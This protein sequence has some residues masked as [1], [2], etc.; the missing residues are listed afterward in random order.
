MPEVIEKSQSK[1]APMK[2]ASIGIVVVAAGRGSRAQTEL[3]KQ[4][5]TLAGKTV[6][7]RTLEA[8]QK[9]IPDARIVCVIHPDDSTLYSKA[10]EGLAGLHHVLGGK[11]RQESVLNGLN[12]LKAESP[13]YAFVHDAARPFVSEVLIKN[14]L[15]TLNEGS[16][17]V[18]PALAV[19]DTLKRVDQNTIAD[20]VDRSNLYSVQTPQ[21]FDFALLQNAHQAAPHSDFTDDAAVMEA[22]GHTVQICLGDDHNFK[23][24]KPE[25]FR[26]AESQIMM[27]CA[28]V[29]VGTGY[30][31]HQLEPGDG[32]WLCGIKIPH[33]HSLKGHSDADAGLHALTDAILAA[34][35]EGDIGTHFPP[36]D[37]KW[38]GMDSGVFL[39]HAHKL[40]TDKGGII[41]HLT[42]CLICE[43][44]KIGPHKDAMRARIAE[45]LDMDIGRISVQATTT[46]KLGFTGRDE[47]IAAQAT[48][49]V[50]LPLEVK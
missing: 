49:T 20:T 27:T 47:G 40:V 14:I 19:T 44:P 8:L 41:A 50:R 30:D 31:V 17:A 29:R 1:I 3:P 48:A 16:K 2:E 12:A 24:T 28:D 15:E 38:R 42:V 5:C 11:T 33:S 9:A 25:D 4:Y 6:L 13:D 23:I 34:I 46:E 39:K 37:E 45:L 7:R 36:S 18:I 35:A 43:K 26:K 22:A 32:P 10:S 21:A